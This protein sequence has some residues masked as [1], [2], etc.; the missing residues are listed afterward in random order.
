[1]NLLALMPDQ[2]VCDVMVAR[3]LATLNSTHPIVD[4]NSLQNDIDSFWS[5]K[6]PRSAPWLAFYLAIVALGY[7]L[8]V[9]LPPDDTY[10]TN[11]RKLGKTLM[12]SVL[13]HGIALAQNSKR[14]SIFTF[15]TMLLLILQQKL[16]LDWVDGFDVTSG[17]LGSLS[18]MVGTMG[19]HRDSEG[20][21]NL[22]DSEV[23]VRR[24]VR[25]F[26]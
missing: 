5:T 6:S 14:P 20:V 26:T 24:Q 25:L 8:P 7:Q 23:N 19:L 22:D 13:I 18:R 11:G 21:G 2:P 16:D 4:V 15:Q 1:M 9:N 17:L 3:F 10:D 12:E